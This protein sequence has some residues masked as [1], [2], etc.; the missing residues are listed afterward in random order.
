MAFRMAFDFELMMETS[1]GRHQK[2]P[3]ELFEV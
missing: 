3:E 2:R 1:M